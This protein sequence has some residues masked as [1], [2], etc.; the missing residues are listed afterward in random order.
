MS[1]YKSS[2]DEAAILD[3]MQIDEEV[4]K[5]LALSKA[6]ERKSPQ[7]T[8]KWEKKKKT[9]T[10]QLWGLIGWG[11]NLE[12]VDYEWADYLASLGLHF[13]TFKVGLLVSGDLLSTVPGTG[14]ALTA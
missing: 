13:L 4:E 2:G 10:L 8:K 7:D 6:D 11:W 9:Q 3:H 1:L 14:E 12:S 5:T